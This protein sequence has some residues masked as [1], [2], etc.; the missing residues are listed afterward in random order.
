MLGYADA[1]YLEMGYKREF[2]EQWAYDKLL[3][4]L[5]ETLSEDDIAQLSTEGA[6]WSEDRAVEEAMQA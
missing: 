5:R 3:V 2:T 1:R 6:T 4:A